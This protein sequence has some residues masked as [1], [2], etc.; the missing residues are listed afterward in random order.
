MRGKKIPYTENELLW[1]ESNCTLPISDLHQ[2]FCLQFCR[3]D[4]SPNNLAALRKRNGWL[5]GRTGQFKKGNIPHPNARPKGP[6]TT[7]F[8]KGS[9]PHNY[10]P[11]GSTRLSKDGYVEVKIADPGKWVFMHNHVWTNFNGDIPKGFCVS[12]IDGD[13]S[14]ATIEN[15]EL[16]SRNENL[17]INRISKGCSHDEIRPSFRILGK[18]RAKII[19]FSG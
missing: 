17:Q 11:I 5:T 16:I 14:N 1:V 19:E 3:E 12:F 10:K 9:V 7:S 18:L 13:R 8:E 2:Q 15:L 6:N 4:V